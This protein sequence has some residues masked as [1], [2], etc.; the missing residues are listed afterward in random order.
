MKPGGKPGNP[1]AFRFFCEH[2]WEC[3]YGNPYFS[4]FL[5]LFLIESFFLLLSRW[6]GSGRWLLN[7][8]NFFAFFSFVLLV[9]FFSCLECLCVVIFVALS[10]LGYLLLCYGGLA[11]HTAMSHVTLIVASSVAL[12]LVHIDVGHRFRLHRVPTHEHVLPLCPWPLYS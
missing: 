4:R 8:C 3:L 6:D 10:G 9:I 1:L 7:L 5:F 2:L 11:W 12:G